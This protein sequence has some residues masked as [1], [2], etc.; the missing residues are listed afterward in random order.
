[1]NKIFAFILMHIGFLLYSFYTVLGKIASGYEPLSL[2]FCIF[3]CILIFILFVYALLW[4]QVLKKIPLTTATANKAI[5]IIWGM[6]WSF[7]FFSE[8]ITLKKVLGALIIIFGI[9]LLSFSEKINLKIQNRNKNE[10]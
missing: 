5:T 6:I 1:M 8:K 3:Y 10:Q 2:N 7:L 4:Q 9:T